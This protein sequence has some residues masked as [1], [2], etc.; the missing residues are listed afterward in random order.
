MNNILVA[1]WGTNCI[2]KFS[3]DGEFI[4]TVLSSEDGENKVRYPWGIA[5]TDSGMLLVSEQK[6]DKKD[7]RLKLFEC[8][9]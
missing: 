5:T 1:D 4:E 6:L 9:K 7:P 3:P 8:G 2:S